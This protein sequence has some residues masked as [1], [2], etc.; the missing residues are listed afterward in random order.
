MSKKKTLAWISTDWS[1]NEER[2]KNNTFGGV[3]YYRL[4]KPMQHLED[5][6]DC[7]YYGSNI[8]EMAKGLSTEEFYNSF[9]L[10]HDMIIVKHVDNPQAIGALT[11]YCKMHAVPLVIDLDDN[12][13]EIRA[14]QP[15]YKLYK[16]G[17]QKRAFMAA[18]VSLADAIFSSTEPLKEKIE[19]YNS[20]VFKMNT[21]VYTLPNCNDIVD[22]PENKGTDDKF[23]IGWQ[24]S[25][26]HNADL[27]IV[28]PLIDKI[29]TKYPQVHLEL[30]GG[31][32]ESKIK[33]LFKDFSTEN[34]DKVTVCP[35][36]Q[37]WDG[38]PELLS[39]QSWK[40]GIAPLVDEPFNR[41]KSHI[42]WMEY[43][44]QKIPCVASN[45]YPYAQDI[46]GVKTIQ[47]GKTGFLCKPEEWEKTLEN[48]IENPHILKE[49]GQSAYDDVVKN[50]QYKDHSYKWKEA[51]EDVFANYKD[52]SAS[53]KKQLKAKK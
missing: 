37:S 17:E 19:E 9:V 43:A 23:I 6:Y 42:K 26:T 49:V 2:K 47:H 41:S 3:T 39:K 16:E 36:T 50:W 44:T 45:V 7:R 15:A 30:M 22:F 13:Y 40:I 11:F 29:M 10:Q 21:K 18:F 46:H 12:L 31:I 53:I 14:D 4:V 51:I 33:E 8:Q 25:T 20:K 27:M 34:L 5:E 52:Q 28:L 1:V 24:G 38:Y 32:E 48:L 35:G